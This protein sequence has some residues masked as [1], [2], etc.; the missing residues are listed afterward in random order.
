[1]KRI[2][3]EEDNKEYKDMDLK[4]VNFVN[5]NDI[6]SKRINNKPIEN[7]GEIQMKKLNRKIK[8]FETLQLAV[9]MLLP[10]FMVVDWFTI[11]QR[12]VTLLIETMSAVIIV[13]LIQL[14]II[15]L[16]GEIK[17]KRVEG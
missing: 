15:A 7:K 17:L 10:F 2:Y 8:M 4:V 12:H 14:K 3:P 9:T 1:M 5:D 16:R 6:L 11:D 13:L